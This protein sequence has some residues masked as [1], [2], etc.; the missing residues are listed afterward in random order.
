MEKQHSYGLPAGIS[1]Y[2]IFFVFFSLILLGASGCASKKPHYFG[3]LD[4]YPEFRP[5]PKGGVDLV[6]LKDGADFK[7]Y[8]KVMLDHIIFFTDPEARFKGVEADE[9]KKLEVSFHSALKNELEKEYPYVSYP[10]V[11]DELKKLEV[12]FHSALKNELEK[13]YP[14]VSYPI[15]NEPGPDVMKLR[16]AV[17]TLNP[18]R[19]VVCG[20]AMA[21]LPISLTVGEVDQA[22]TGKNI[23]TG[24]ATIE[25]EMLDSMTNERIAAAIDNYNGTKDSCI[26]K[27]GLAHE[28]FAFWAARL[29]FFMDTTHGN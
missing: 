7:K 4:P 2:V 22:I 8:N 26:E 14:Y 10:I 11:N 13:E 21:L 16:V 15:V 19:P 28:A 24:N 6:Y 25:A 23:G 18:G 27:E 20:A 29:R 3:F 12:S 5:G 9:L 1:G 17:T